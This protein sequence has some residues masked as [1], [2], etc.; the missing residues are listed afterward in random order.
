MKMASSSSSSKCGKYD[1]FLSFRGETRKKLTDNLACTLKTRG[2]KIFLDENELTRGE[3]ITSELKQAIQ[4]SR[5]AA[6]IFSRGYA[7]SRWCLEELVEILVCKETM[8]LMVLP[9]FYDIDTTDV[10]DQTRDFEEAFQSLQERFPDKV[11]TWKDALKAA[12]ELTGESLS[13]TAG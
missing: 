10:R 12:A 5:L 8:G 4:D 3:P 7:G 11:Q 1:V 9:V 2:F 6:I 13:A